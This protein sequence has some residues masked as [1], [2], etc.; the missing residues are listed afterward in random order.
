MK[1]YLIQ[2]K[3]SNY[4]KIGISKNIKRR[5]ANLQSG[6][7][8]KLYVVRYWDIPKEAY[9]L[10][11]LLHCMFAEYHVLLEWF[12]VEDV[13]ILLDGI[14]RALEFKGILV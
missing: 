13:T 1:L 5:L 8:N 6:N 10:E 7:P 14:K 9:K 2:Q 4:F 3:G 11:S 12:E